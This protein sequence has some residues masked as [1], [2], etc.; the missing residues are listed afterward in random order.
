MGGTN[1]SRSVVASQNRRTGRA[2][3]SRPI[4]ISYPLDVDLVATAGAA[5]T[6]ATTSTSATAATSSAAGAATLLALHVG[7]ADDE[8][9]SHQAI[10][11]VDLGALH[12]GSAL[13]V[14]EH[15]NILGLDDDVIGFL[16]LL[17][18]K[19]VLKA[20]MATGRYHDPEQSPFLPLIAEHL[21]QLFGRERRN[22]N[23]L[24]RRQ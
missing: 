12:E 21:G 17:D 23:D 9:A 11:V 5:F 10:D 19:H 20:T 22:L 7:I 16:F 24:S 13:G 15:S 1:L 2:C 18:A 8:P 3:S 14:H 4:F 6:S